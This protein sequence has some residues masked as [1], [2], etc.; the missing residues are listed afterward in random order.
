MNQGVLQCFPWKE[1]ATQCQ[2]SPGDSSSSVLCILM[3]FTKEKNAIVHDPLIQVPSLAITV[4]LSMM[5][6]VL[7]LW[8]CFI[9]II[10]I[11]VRTFNI[12]MY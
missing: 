3:F 1:I 5:S 9:W 2:G 11:Y 12:S 10:T 4:K 8:F 6:T 7:S